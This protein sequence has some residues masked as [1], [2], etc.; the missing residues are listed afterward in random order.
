MAKIPESNS[1][2][3]V[4]PIAQRLVGRFLLQVENRGQTWFVDQLGYKHKVTSE[5]I[6]EV[7]SKAVL[8]IDNEKL[9]EIPLAENAQ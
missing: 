8:G 9:E 4:T 2:A 6:L 5:N 3:P 1:S 7:A